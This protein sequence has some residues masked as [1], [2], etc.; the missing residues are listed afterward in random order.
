MSAATSTLPGAGTGHTLSP[1]STA[2]TMPAAM[3]ES[4]SKTAA[5]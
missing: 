4:A 2:G 5:L 1:T 3:S